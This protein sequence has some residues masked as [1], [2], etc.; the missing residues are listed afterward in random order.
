MTTA[1]AFIPL[2][3]ESKIAFGDFL[4]EK[5]DIEGK[6]KCPLDQMTFD[7]KADL[8]RHYRRVHIAEANLT[9]IG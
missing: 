6:Y 2:N 5:K 8:D 7:S 1:I 3:V 9:N 4:S